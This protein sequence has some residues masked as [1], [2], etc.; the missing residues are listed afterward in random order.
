LE[1][2][3]HDIFQGTIICPENKSKVVPVFK[4]YAMK[5]WGS[6]GKT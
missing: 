1:G 2:D 3:G 6:G 4:Y 5:T